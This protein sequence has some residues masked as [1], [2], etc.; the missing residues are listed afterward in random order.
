M[1]LLG[2]RHDGTQRRCGRAERIVEPGGIEL[3]VG[4][5]DAGSLGQV[6]QFA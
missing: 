5:Q 2:I 1:A 6:S 4:G 3:S